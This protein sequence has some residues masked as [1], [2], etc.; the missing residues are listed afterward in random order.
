MNQSTKETDISTIQDVS[1]TK[2]KHL[3]KTRMSYL[4]GR[5]GERKEGQ[6]PTLRGLDKIL[7]S[8]LRG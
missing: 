2:Q 5:E 6:M 1:K 7:L 4:E 8:Y 3:G